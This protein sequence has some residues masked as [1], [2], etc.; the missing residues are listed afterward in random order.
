MS[1]LTG[2]DWANID[3]SQIERNYAKYQFKQS[4]VFLCTSSIQSTT[5]NLI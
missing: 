3:K 1:M 2:I 5:I 4:L